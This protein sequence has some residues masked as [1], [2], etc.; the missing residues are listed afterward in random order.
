MNPERVHIICYN[1]N[2]MTVSKRT[3]SQ[4]KVSVQNIYPWVHVAT[5][6]YLNKN[7]LRRSYVSPV[8]MSSTECQYFVMNDNSMKM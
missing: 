8:N 4:P 7:N 5:N 3:K 6:K 2:D 1:L